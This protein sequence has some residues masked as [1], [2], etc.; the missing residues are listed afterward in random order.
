MIVNRI[1]GSCKSFVCNKLF[2]KDAT[3]SII[4]KQIVENVTANVF[5]AKLIQPTIN[6]TQPFY[7][8]TL[9]LILYK[10]IIIIIVEN[11]QLMVF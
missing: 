3:Q 5:C 1:G 6:A 2:S 11:T 7:I 4:E 9:I 10:Y 8:S